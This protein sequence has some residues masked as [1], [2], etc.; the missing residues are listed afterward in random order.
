MNFFSKFLVKKKISDLENEVSTLKEE[1]NK[2]N[3]KLLE[4]QEHINKTN[5]FW[6]KKLH[7]KKNKS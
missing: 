4:K 7:E 3:K 6:K 1:L 5:A 2:C